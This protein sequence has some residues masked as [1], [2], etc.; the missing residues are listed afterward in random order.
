MQWGRQSHSLKI[1]KNFENAALG[2]GTHLL[3]WLAH[4]LGKQPGLYVC[5]CFSAYGIRGPVG[6]ARP[7]RWAR[8]A[9]SHLLNDPKILTGYFVSGDSHRVRQ[10]ESG[11]LAHLLSGSSR[12]QASSAENKSS[13]FSPGGTSSNWRI[14]STGKRAC[15]NFASSC[16]SAGRVTILKREGFFLWSAMAEMT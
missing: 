14:R 10:V 1:L 16:A 11:L 12:A 15:W 4:F 13:S 3:F 8:G 2:V 5:G 6:F 9:C 7:V